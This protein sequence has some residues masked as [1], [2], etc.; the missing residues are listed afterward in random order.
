[1]KTLLATVFALSAVATVLPATAFA[2][3]AVG[4]VIGTGAGPVKAALAKLGCPVE[5]FEAEGGRIDARCTD[6]A[7]GKLMEISIDPTT[8]VVASIKTGD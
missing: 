1:M 8:G 3:P 2:L 5:G 4:D 7:T 6:G